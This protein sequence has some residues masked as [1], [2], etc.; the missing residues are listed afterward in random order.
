LNK[1]EEVTLDMSIMKKW[2][3]EILTKSQ[4]IGNAEWRKRVVL[5]VE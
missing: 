2:K 4:R 5:T 3:K 1:I